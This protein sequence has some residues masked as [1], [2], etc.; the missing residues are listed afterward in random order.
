MKGWKA[1]TLTE[2][3]V[4]KRAEGS[5]WFSSLDSVCRLR[6]RRGTFFR[7]GEPRRHFFHARITSSAYAIAV[8]YK[9]SLWVGHFIKLFGH[10]S[11][12]PRLRMRACQLLRL[13]PLFFL[14]EEIVHMRTPPW[15]KPQGGTTSLGGCH[16]I[17]KPDSDGSSEPPIPRNSKHF[18]RSSPCLST[19]R[20][21]GNCHNP[22]PRPETRKD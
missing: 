21:F 15:G 20:G 3:R 8:T 2:V 13:H 12:L 22:I 1:K 9:P 17:D 6:G 4:S 19:S 11:H 5:Q 18:H 10:S 14:V 16:V 7:R